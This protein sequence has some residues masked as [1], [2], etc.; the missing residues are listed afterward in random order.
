MFQS[1]HLV[2][3]LLIDSVVA[4]VS[5][6]FTLVYCCVFVLLPFLGEQRFTYLG[7]RSWG[8]RATTVGDG[9]RSGWVTVSFVGADVRGRVNDLHSRFPVIS[10]RSVAAVH[11]Q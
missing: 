5:S 9:Y 4:F 2:S 1:E 11:A 6:I 7:V 8:S 10:M 3:L